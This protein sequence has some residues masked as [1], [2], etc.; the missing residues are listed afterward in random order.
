MLSV[1][2]GSRVVTIGHCI[3][4]VHMCVCLYYINKIVCVEKGMSAWS[5]ES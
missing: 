5:I 4:L 2:S 3:S 1:Y